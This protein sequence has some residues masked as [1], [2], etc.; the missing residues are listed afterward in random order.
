MKKLLLLL[1]I[2][3]TTVLEPD[4]RDVLIGSW[5]DDYND[6]HPIYTFYRNRTFE[7]T[8]NGRSVVK[9]A[10]W[11]ATH[12]SIYLSYDCYYIDWNYTEAAY[13]YK[14]YND[15]LEFIDIKGSHYF[16]RAYDF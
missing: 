12:D 7:C 2:G 10:F 15:T 11:S 14:I 3:C 8:H 4:Y 16:E 1:F 6:Y 9:D 5:K 13:R